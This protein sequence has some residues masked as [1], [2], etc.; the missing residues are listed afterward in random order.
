M[1]WFDGKVSEEWEQQAIE[2]INDLEPL[3]S[4]ER[5]ALFL[6]LYDY[7]KSKAS[8]DVREALL[9][10]IYEK[11]LQERTWWHW[12]EYEYWRN[13]YFS[14]IHPSGF[15]PKLDP[16]AIQ[17]EDDIYKWATLP[18]LKKMLA[19][20][21]IEPPKKN[22]TKGVA[23]MIKEDEKLFLFIKRE[24]CIK[25]KSREFNLFVCMISAR[26][27]SLLVAK[28]V[29]TYGL[30]AE[31]YG[32]EPRLEDQ[33]RALALKRKPKLVPPYWPGAHHWIASH[34]RE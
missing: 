20:I 14:G 2:A 11:H 8:Y 23:K 21:N 32:Y 16:Y 18:A 15:S 7:E 29:A 31:L 28:D 10:N 25:I 4:E 13:L 34:G 6:D 22:V 12:G 3:T 5:K 24:L 17:R 33:F 9:D 27:S 26:E 30:K 1:S 19:A